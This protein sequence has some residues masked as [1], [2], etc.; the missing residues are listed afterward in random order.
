M[1]FVIVTKDY[2]GLGFAMRLMDEGH[3]VLVAF[4]GSY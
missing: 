1:N 3:K 2:S 4:K